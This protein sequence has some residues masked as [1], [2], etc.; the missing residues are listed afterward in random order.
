MELK[1][2][3]RR[4]DLLFARFSGTVEERQ[5]CLVIQTPDNPG[6]HSGNYLLFDRPPGRGDFVRWKALFDALIPYPTHHYLFCWDP[7]QL[8]DPAEFLAAGFEVDSAVVL[9]CSRPHRSSRGLETLEVRPL[10]SQEDWERAVEL[11][12][13][14]A[15]PKYFDP[16]YGAFKKK[17]M[18]QYRKMTE[19]GLGLWYG[20]F[21]GGR[22]VGNLGIF[23]EG[24]LAR[25]QE[26]G[27]DPGFRRRGVCGTLV[28]R[29]SRDFEKRFG[30]K[31]FVLEAEAGG[32]AER[33]YRSVGFEE[34]ETNYNLVWWE[35]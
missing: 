25:Y 17:Q 3:G 8:G 27:T 7:P 23:T 20:G 29:A 5:G 33:I 32:A 19:A 26:V 11:Q 30:Q 16:K 1:S 2:L 34:V 35:R 6:Y 24:H 12:F 4:T 18:D 10:T 21:E 13:R 22:L 31:R 15:D 9:A 28:V 14:C